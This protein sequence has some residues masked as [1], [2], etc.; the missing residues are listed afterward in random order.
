MCMYVTAPLTESAPMLVI[1][2][3]PGYPYKDMNDTRTLVKTGTATFFDEAYGHMNGNYNGFPQSNVVH[4]MVYASNGPHPSD[5]LI[6]YNNGVGVYMDQVTLVGAATSTTAMVLE[7]IQ[8][9]KEWAKRGSGADGGGHSFG[10]GTCFWIRACTGSEKV[11][12]ACSATLSNVVHNGYCFLSDTESLECGKMTATDDE[13]GEKPFS[14]DLERSPNLLPSVAGVVDTEPDHGIP[15]TTVLHPVSST[16]R[17]CPSYSPAKTLGAFVSK[18]PL[19]AGCMITSDASYDQLA[20]VHVPAYCTTPADYMKGCM[21]PT[22]INF[23]PT[24][25]QVDVCKFTASGCSS[26][27]AVNY[28]SHA[29]IDDGSCIQKVEG[30]SV[31]AATYSGVNPG[32]PSY[33]SGYYGSTV[34]LNWGKQLDSASNPAYT[35]TTVANPTPNAN[36]NTN[37]IAAVEGCMDP[38]ARNYDA[39]ATVNSNTWCVPD[40]SGCMIPDPAHA[41]PGMSIPTMTISTMGSS[42]AAVAAAAALGIPAVTYSGGSYTTDGYVSSIGGTY[43]TTTTRNVVSM[44]GATKF[45]CVNDTSAYNYDPQATAQTICWSAKVGCLNPGASN[46]MCPS[47]AYTTPCLTMTGPDRVTTH[48]KA[49]CNFGARAAAP[50]APA[51]PADQADPVYKVEIAMTVAGTVASVTAQEATF[52]SIFRTMGGFD[53]STVITFTATDASSRRRLAAGRALQSGGVDIS[54]EAE[55]ADAAAAETASSS[56]ATAVGTSGASAT[57]A[58]AATGITVLSAP[59]VEAKTEY[60]VRSDAGGS[61]AGGIIGGIAGG[62]GGLLMAIGIFWYLKKKKGKSKEVYPA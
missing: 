55:V 48:V 51:P 45:G 10:Y 31:T 37:C 3:P 29:T 21:T 54:M 42:A 38:T 8:H 46:F 39:Q 60:V 5:E 12:S 61:A 16:V 26:S 35:G 15:A 59:V 2:K 18:R 22:A 25:K 40:V 57:A 50:V 33:K 49:I 62:L 47:D 44:C 36:V 32:T 6:A 53:A 7:S 9:A 43:A 19:N 34:G 27:T 14:F 24:A 28:N 20:E 30:C 1:P 41:G 23:D 13:Y 11:G 58:F 4:N 56:V 17:R 52:V